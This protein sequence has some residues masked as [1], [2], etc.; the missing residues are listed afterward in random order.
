M[1]GPYLQAAL[2]CEKVLQEQDGVLSVI[3]VVDRHTATVLGPEVPADMPPVAVNATVLVILKQGD[4]IGRYAIKL[5]P[6][7]PSGQ[8]LPTLEVPVQFVEGAGEQGVN[9]VI[10]MNLQLQEE[11]LYWFDVIWSDPRGGAEEG[12]LTRVPLRVM[13]QPQQLGIGGPATGETP[14]PNS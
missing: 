4:A 11:G 5:R 12:L 9:I 6:E 8:Q 13:Y 3:R 7:A 14:P 1:P 10:P 2:I